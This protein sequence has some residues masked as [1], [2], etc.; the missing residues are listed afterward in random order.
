MRQVPALPNVANSH[1]KTNWT[2]K[3]TTELTKPTKEMAMPRIRLGNNSENNT[4][5][6]GPTEMAGRVSSPS[7]QRQL[8]SAK[9]SDCVQAASDLPSCRIN[10]VIREE[11]Y[12]D[13]DHA[14]DDGGVKAHLKAAQGYD[15][16]D[17]DNVTQ[18]FVHVCWSF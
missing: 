11:R 17:A 15:E 16:G 13:T 18:P 7:I 4:H 6:T 12:G 2:R 3:L 1:G 9:P 5:M 8:Y 14:G 10:Q